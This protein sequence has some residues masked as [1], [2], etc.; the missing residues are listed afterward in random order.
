MLPVPR[1]SRG[2]GHGNRQCRPTGRLRGNSRRP[3]RAG[4]GRPAQSAARRDRAT[5]RLR[6]DGEEVGHVG[7]HGRRVAGRQCRA[8]PGARA[9]QGNRRL[10]RTGHRR[11]AAQISLLAGHHRRP[12][13]GRHAGRGR[14]VRR[15][16]DVFATGGQ[17]RSGDEKI[18]GP[19]APLY[20]AGKG[21]KR[22]PASPRQSAHG[23]GQRRRSRHRQEHRGRGAGLQQLRG[24]RPG[25]HGLLRKNSG[26]RSPGTG[27][28]DRAERPDYAQPGRDGT[29]RARDGAGRHANAAVDR[30]RDHQRQAHGRQD[31][32]G[33]RPADRACARC[34]AVGGSRR[35]IAQPRAA[36][37]VRREKSERAGR[38]RGLLSAPAG[39]QA[40]ALSPRPWPR[41]FRPN[42][43]RFRS[44]GPPF[45]ARACSTITR[46]KN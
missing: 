35:P 32:A 7:G 3:A 22:R 8:A 34:L 24:H 21:G 2:H 25:C 31:R 5:D 18:R 1:Y 39:N 38:T 11:G 19:F 33:L 37:G 6:R 43:P 36:R 16:Q 10:R 4:R 40:G 44:S 12:A 15:G 28:F 14:S 30:R 13:D 17:E 42:G 45:S 26:N 41:N 23:H 20:G 46:W 9:G 27:R 29:R